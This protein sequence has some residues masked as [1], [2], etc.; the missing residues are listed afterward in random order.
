ML[1]LLNDHEGE[2]R[3]RALHDIRDGGSVVLLLLY[4][5]VLKVVY[6]HVPELREGRFEYRLLTGEFHEDY[7]LARANLTDDLLH[8]GGGGEDE[9]GARVR[10][11]PLLPFPEP[12]ALQEVSLKRRE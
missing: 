5:H 8:R 11:F 6:L 7:G 4:A 12:S 1:L 9:E 3:K 10:V 2:V